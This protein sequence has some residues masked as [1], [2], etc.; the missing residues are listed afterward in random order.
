MEN[1]FVKD[2]S[3]QENLSI[4]SMEDSRTIVSVALQKLH[5]LVLGFLCE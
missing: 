3:L 2:I 4:S 5:K 1:V